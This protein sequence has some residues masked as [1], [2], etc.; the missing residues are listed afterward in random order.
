MPLRR[1]KHPGDCFPRRDHDLALEKRVYIPFVGD[2]LRAKWL[3]H[4]VGERDEP[5]ERVDIVAELLNL[6]VAQHLQAAVIDRRVVDV[7]L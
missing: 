6:S 3:F 1:G 4:A 5:R 7:V 2:C